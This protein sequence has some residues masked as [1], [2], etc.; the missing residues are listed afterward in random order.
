M[1]DQQEPRPIAS[2]EMTAGVF[3][4]VVEVWAT[5][6]AITLDFLRTDPA[7][8]AAGKTIRVARVAMSPILAAQAMDR[9][10]KGVAEY[11]RKGLRLDAADDQ[12]EGGDDEG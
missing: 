6:H 1:P 4:D 9:L 12:K 11:T 5:K 10:D 3:A 7:T 8:P 2:A